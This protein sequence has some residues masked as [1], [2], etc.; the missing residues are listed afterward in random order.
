MTS[1]GTDRSGGMCSCCLEMVRVTSQTEQNGWVCWSVRCA[2]NFKDT[3][4]RRLGKGLQSS[5]WEVERQFMTFL[6]LSVLSGG[7]QRDVD[8]NEILMN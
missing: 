3:A 5:S 4:S 8:T 7:L 6:C 2:V 1:G